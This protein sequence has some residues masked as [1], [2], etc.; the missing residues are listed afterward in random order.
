[1][2][3]DGQEAV[4]WRQKVAFQSILLLRVTIGALEYKSTGVPSWQILSESQGD[5]GL[6]TGDELFGRPTRQCELRSCSGSTDNFRTPNM[7]AFV[8]RQTLLEPRSDPAI[9]PRHPLIIGEEVKLLQIVSDFCCAVEQLKK[10]VGTPF[11][12]PLEQM[13]RTL[14]LFWIFSLPL[15]LIREDTSLWSALVIMCL[16]TFGYM[17]LEY[18]SLEFDDPFGNDPNDFPTQAWAEQV[19]EDVY[20][21]VHRT[22]GRKSMTDLQARVNVVLLRASAKPGVSSACDSEGY[23]TRFDDLTLDSSCQTLDSSLVGIEAA[24]MLAEP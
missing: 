1:M 6:I 8:L 24:D 16:I 2:S 18:V 15:V 23:R 4:M 21:M 19:Y 10:L 3:D 17:G 11:S 7:L 5:E 20:M 9:L 12:F 22:D 13:T 14:L